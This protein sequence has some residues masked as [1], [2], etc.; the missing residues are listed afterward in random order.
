M[1][2][3]IYNNVIT[4]WFAPATFY[5]ILFTFYILYTSKWKYESYVQFATNIYA[6]LSCHILCILKLMSQNRYQTRSVKDTIFR[7]KFYGI[8][9]VSLYPQLVINIPTEVSVVQLYKQ[10][11]EC[12][13]ITPVVKFHAVSESTCL[14]KSMSS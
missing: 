10:L 11:S 5:T 7:P 4:T 1:N 13:P 12:S 8:C 9:G 6:K 3:N 14:I 2:I